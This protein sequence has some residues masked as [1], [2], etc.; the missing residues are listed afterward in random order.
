MNHRVEIGSYNLKPGTREEFHRLFL[1]EALP[2]LKRLNV[3]V[4]AYGPSLHD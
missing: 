4:M 2:M 3:D 1:E